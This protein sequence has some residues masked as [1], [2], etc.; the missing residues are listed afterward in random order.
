MMGSKGS[1]VTQIST[2]KSPTSPFPYNPAMK[3]YVTGHR[4]KEVEEHGASKTHFE[5]NKDNVNIYFHKY[6][7]WRLESAD[8]AKRERDY[9]EKMNVHVGDHY[10]KFS[11]EELPE[12]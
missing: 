4:G 12:G 7:G 5:L 2:E 10:C 1:F 8:D 11:V 9:L 6:A 3:V